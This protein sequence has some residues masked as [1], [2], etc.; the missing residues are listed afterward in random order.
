MFGWGECEW[1]RAF[2]KA[3]SD[4]IP[5]NSELSKDIIKGLLVAAAVFL[6]TL[7]AGQTV[8]ALKWLKGYIV[9]TDDYRW[10]VV[11][12]RSAVDPKSPGLWLAIRH[13]RPPH[14]GERMSAHPFVMT[15]ANDKG[16]GAIAK[17]W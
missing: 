14:Y 15:V 16:G 11:R 8:K 4:A 17:S 3:L 5:G 10:R 6:F 1:C 12:T 13:E 9:K 7:L 2:W